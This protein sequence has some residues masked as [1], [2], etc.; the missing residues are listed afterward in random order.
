MTSHV[1]D[2]T[3]SGLFHIITHPEVDLV[4]C[5]LTYVTF[6][7]NFSNQHFESIYTMNFLIKSVVP[8]VC[9]T[10]LSQ[11]HVRN[12]VYAFLLSYIW[13]KWLTFL[14]TIY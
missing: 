7:I 6:Q 5:H 1:I 13:F 4:I 8:L 14:Q 3:L 2:F 11:T 9:D 10:S 12:K